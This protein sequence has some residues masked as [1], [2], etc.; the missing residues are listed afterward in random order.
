MGVWKFVELKFMNIHRHFYV[1]SFPFFIQGIPP[2]C[3]IS[4]N[5]Y[6]AIDL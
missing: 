4:T 2:L 1:D 5:L 6:Y 3:V